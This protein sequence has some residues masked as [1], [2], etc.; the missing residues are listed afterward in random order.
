MLPFTLPMRQRYAAPQ[1]RLYV[2]IEEL[3][4]KDTDNRLGQY[5]GRHQQQ[6]GV[7]WW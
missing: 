1:V 5:A 6:W 2:Y 3:R 7:A 4:V